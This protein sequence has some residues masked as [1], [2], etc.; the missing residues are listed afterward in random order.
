MTA[1]VETIEIA[2]SAEDVFTY[3]TDPSRFGEWQK[4]IVG[5]HM[6]EVGRRRPGRDA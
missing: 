1:I 4:N 2:R 5:G 3:V 6:E